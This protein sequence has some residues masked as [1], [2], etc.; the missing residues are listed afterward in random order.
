MPDEI[1]LNYL[2]RGYF[3]QDFDLVAE[4]PIAVVRKFAYE[5]DTDY[6]Q[7]M[8]DELEEIL[9]ARPSEGEAKQLWIGDAH[10]MYDPARD[11]ISY[12]A[13]LSEVLEIAKEALRN[14]PDDDDY[15]D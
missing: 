6:I 9:S 13:W 11:G 1:M 3:H 4:S 7:I 2:G 14:R 15:H 12:L 10:A 8:A 5:E